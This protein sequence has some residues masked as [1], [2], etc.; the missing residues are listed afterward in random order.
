MIIN[1]LQPIFRIKIHFPFPPPLF[2]A[3]RR[4][5]IKK[6]PRQP[7]YNRQITPSRQVYNPPPVPKLVEVAWFVK[8][9]V[10]MISYSIS[11][12]HGGI[13]PSFRN[14][15]FLYAMIAILG[16]LRC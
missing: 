8:D 6:S 4:T 15:P 12:K 3:K 1:Q 14:V 2:P 13:A 16:R 10:S 7:P 9:V 11:S 5:T